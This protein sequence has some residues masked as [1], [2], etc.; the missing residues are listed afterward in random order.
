MTPVTSADHAGSS[1][2]EWFRLVIGILAVGAWEIMSLTGHDVPLIV[3]IVLAAA[4]ALGYG[5]ETFRKGIQA[6]LRFDF[7]SMYFL[8]FIA[9]VGAYA[10]GQFAEA[11]TIVVLFTLSEELEHYGIQSSRSALKGLIERI[12]KTA[13]VIEKQAAIPI[14]QLQIGDKI[15]ILP[16]EIVPMDGT[17]ISGSSSVDESTI[18]GEPIPV[19]RHKGDR[20]FAGTMNL[21]GALDVQVTSTAQ[22]STLAKIVELTFNAAKDKAPSQQ[23]IERF[24]RFYTPSIVGISVGLAIIPPI[25][26]HQDFTKWLMQ[27]LSLLVIGCP[28]ALVI[29][30]PIA[31][32]SA[33]GA[34][35][36]HGVVVK[37]GRSLEA[38]GSIRVMALD[39]TRTLT[40]GKPIVT[41]ILPMNGISKEHLLACAAGIEQYSEHPLARSIVE[42]ANEEQVEPHIIE[43]FQSVF[44]M[45]AKAECLVCEDREHTIGKLQFIQASTNVQAE[46]LTEVDR[47]QAEGKTS[48]IIASNDVE[49]IIALSDAVRSESKSTIAQIKA[50]NITPI[51]LTGDNL[52]SAKII[53]GHVGIEDV[54]ADLLPEMKA[55]AVKDLKQQFGPIAMVGDGVNDAPALAAATVGIAM[56][57]SG[58][59]MAIEAASI[60]LL[61]DNISLLPYLIKLGRRTVRLIKAN[62]AFTL[63]VKAAF[64]VLAVAGISNL[65]LALLADVGVTLIVVLVG[66]SLMR[67]SPAATR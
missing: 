21:N 61:N 14:Q 58:S 26:L 44:G 13:Y 67:F 6:V 46:V 35:S 39:K 32:F 45:G 20:V 24:A 40:H 7:R 18:T 50:L 53:A 42:A 36:R 51:M 28:C 5:R 60:A 38:L 10:T 37:G 3:G 1:N 31:I 65:A 52:S 11:S 8:M 43:N 16:S 12:P 22:H 54:R 29:S 47:L 4:F 59:D 19:D 25:L 56:G 23:F 62:I 64:I 41:D 33:I 27:A 34:A 2:K 15:R 30:T 63:C 49:G 57:A 17:V 66:L 48:V 9:I 55:N